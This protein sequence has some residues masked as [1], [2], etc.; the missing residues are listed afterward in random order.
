MVK[1]GNT[2]VLPVMSE[3]ITNEDGAEKQ[4]CEQNAMKRWLAAHT[5]AYKWLHATIL[6]DDLFSKYPICQAILQAG[7]SFILTCK[8]ASH[9]WLTETVENSD[10][11]EVTKRDWNGRNHL[12]YTYQWINGV[13]IRDAKETLLVNYM[14]LEIKN[15]KKGKT[16]YKNSWITDK[17]ITADNVQHLTAC[18][19][20]RWKIENEHNN[21]LKNHGYNLE[22]NFGH[23]EQY[24]S[25]VFCLLNLLA[26]QF[27]TI[28]HLCDE[29]YKKLRLLIGR[30]DEFFNVLRA[31]LRF[32]LHESW[33]TFLIFAL[34]EDD[35]VPG[36]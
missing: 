17:T 15:E 3:M 13:A 10:R 32:G 23:G 35:D 21:V 5:E 8:P 33:E 24:A 20:A 30:R 16:T 34:A 4:D 14:S 6:G 31:S 28:L 7:M 36:G 26:F 25:M 18:G 22:H 27:H 12:V 11:N 29:N 1:P 9:P 19:R 2:E